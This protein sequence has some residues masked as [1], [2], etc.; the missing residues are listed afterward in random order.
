[1]LQMITHKGAADSSQGFL[2][3]RDLDEDIRAVAILFD[4]LL[5][6]SNLALDAA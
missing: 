1:M 6:A 4:H 5:E 3:G 2:H